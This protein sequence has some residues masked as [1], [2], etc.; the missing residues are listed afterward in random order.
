M[1]HSCRSLCA[2]LESKALKTKTGFPEIF[3][4]SVQISGLKTSLSSK[5]APIVRRP[6]SLKNSLRLRLGPFV[7]RIRCL[8]I[9]FFFLK[10]KPGKTGKRGTF[11]KLILNADLILFGLI[12]AFL[13]FTHF[14]HKLRES[15]IRH[16]LLG[17]SPESLR[18]IPTS[19]IRFSRDVIRAFPSVHNP[20]KIV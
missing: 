4:Q 16:T 12:L 11:P 14:T 2:L 10:N 15:A 1:H 7:S 5:E 19:K 6:C 9:F 20:T 3:G 18:G 17:R 8:L 13:W